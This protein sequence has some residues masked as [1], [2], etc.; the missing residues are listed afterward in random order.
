MSPGP[1]CLYLKTFFS[2]PSIPGRVIFC[3]LQ[4]VNLHFN[5]LGFRR[6]FSSDNFEKSWKGWHADGTHQRRFAV[7]WTVIMVRVAF[8]GEW[9][10]K[11][12]AAR[13]WRRVVW[14]KSNKVSKI[15]AASKYFNYIWAWPF[16]HG[17]N[18]YGM[19]CRCS[20]PSRNFLL[21][22]ACRP[23]LGP[24]SLSND[25]RRFYL[26]V[27]PSGYAT[28]HSPP[29]TAG[30]KNSWS[31]RTYFHPHTSKLIKLD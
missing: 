26:E 6:L 15:T 17:L 29:S 2:P 16:P 30:V 19:I 28:D 27:K 12:R 23:A 7:V 13:M 5:L 25:Y 20:I 18:E 10:F 14:Y 11:E 4:R 1:S 9:Q 8:S 24:L 21:S 22:T 3:L 31:Y